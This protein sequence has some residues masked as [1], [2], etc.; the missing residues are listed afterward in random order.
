MFSLP[1]I[2]ILCNFVEHSVTIRIIVNKKSRDAKCLR[3]IPHSFYPTV[4]FPFLVL[5]LIYFQ[6][7]FMYV[8]INDKVRMLFKHTPSPI[9]KLYALYRKLFYLKYISLEV[10]QTYSCFRFSISATFSALLIL[11]KDI[12]QSTIRTYFLD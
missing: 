12:K 6:Y 10:C 3:N 8:C 5:I 2:T 11:Q 1:I 4:I 7:N 9:M